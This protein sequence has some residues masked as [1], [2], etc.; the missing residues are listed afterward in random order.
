MVTSGDR[1][2][3]GIGPDNEAE[4]RS[5]G[6]EEFN[7]KCANSTQRY[8]KEW[9]ELTRRMGYWLDFKEAYRTS[10][11][12]YIKRVRMTLGKMYNHGLIYQASKA[13]RRGP[14]TLALR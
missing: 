9:E 2:S 14:A 4:S 5:I 3:K 12:A 7:A 8:I 11:P 13:V 10:D 1:G 6:P